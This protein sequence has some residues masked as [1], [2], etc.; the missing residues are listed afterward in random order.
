MKYKICE[1]PEMFSNGKKP[2]S[3]YDARQVAIGFLNELF[4]RISAADKYL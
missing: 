3:V 1:S 2:G 4:S